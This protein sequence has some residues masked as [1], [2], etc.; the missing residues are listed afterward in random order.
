MV[1]KDIYGLEEIFDRNAERYIS[2]LFPEDRADVRCFVAWLQRSGYK[3]WTRRDL[4]VILRRYM[5]WLGKG[6]AVAW[7]EIKH[8]KSGK[9]F[10]MILMG[11]A[12][13]FFAV[14]FL[15]SAA[16]LALS[17]RNYA[18][19][20]GSLKKVANAYFKTLILS[21]STTK[22]LPLKSSSALST[23]FIELISFSATG[24]WTFSIIMP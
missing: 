3:E 20:L 7:M 21:S 6:E 23:L 13:D 17:P 1:A 19:R 12:F 24:G 15:L 14:L 16:G 5:R 11:S 22:T 9:I 2:K 4:K 10:G 8:P 18:G